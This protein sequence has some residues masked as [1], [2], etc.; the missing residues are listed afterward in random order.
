MRWHSP[1]LAQDAV[2]V[3]IAGSVA[4]ALLGGARFRRGLR[5]RAVFLVRALLVRL[6][7][8]VV[9][10]LA[11]ARRDLHVAEEAADRLADRFAL[12][13]L[14][15]GIADLIDGLSG[16]LGIGEH[17]LDLGLDRRSLERALDADR[18]GEPRKRVGAALAFGSG[19]DLGRSQNVDRALRQVDGA[20]RRHFEPGA[21][22]LQIAGLRDAVLD[23]EGAAE[24]AER[25]LVPGTLEHFGDLTLADLADHL[26]EV[27]AVDRPIAHGETALTLQRGHDLVRV[28]PTAGNLER[29]LG[30][31]FEHAELRGVR[32]QRLGLH[33]IE[34]DIAG[35]LRNRFRRIEHELAGGVPV[36]EIHATARGVQHAITERE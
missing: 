19:G 24:I 22:H 15:Q 30:A 2:E 4:V 1:A 34:P 12:E 18:H 23:G 29:E 17:A 14:L 11:V 35:E 33:A 36:I 8:R 10:A 28:G 13:L 26:G 7:L 9:A 25:R 6:R 3:W 20:G 31:A 32:E 21:G 5:L 16:L 27:D